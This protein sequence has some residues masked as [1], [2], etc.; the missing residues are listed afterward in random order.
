M[1]LGPVTGL[2]GEASLTEAAHVDGHT[3]AVV[4]DLDAGGGEADLDGLPQKLVWDAVEV[5]QHVDG[6]VDVDPGRAPLGDL[7]GRTRQRLE[8][9]TLEGLEVRA[10]GA[11]QL[12]ERPVVEEFEALGDGLV[13][14]G[15]TM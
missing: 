12:L 3:A 11:L 8:R 6:V 15:Q 2:G 9:L 14:V 7:E 1:G 5:A 10:P 4:E 13:E